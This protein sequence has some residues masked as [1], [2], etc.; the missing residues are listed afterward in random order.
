MN[1]QQIDPRSL[2]P[3]PWN[4]NAVGPENME[5]LIASLERH[6]WVRP[7]L[8]RE[9]GDRMQILGGQHR[10]EAAIILGHETVP[11]INLGEIDD[12]RA[13]EIGLI[14]N[15]RYGEDDAIGL[16]ELLHDLGGVGEMSNFLP[17]SNAELAALGTEIDDQE[18]DD[19]L[20][21]T[22]DEKDTEE[23]VKPVKTHQIMRF[24]VPIADADRI[25]DLVERVMEEQGFTEAD[26]L[27]NAGDALV[28]IA[29]NWS[30]ADV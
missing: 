19:L 23:R 11:V 16:M 27:A 5:K 30:D 2:Y 24:K 17:I 29:N 8:A 1:L 21:D 15:A 28:W 13:K 6:G 7:V 25:A 20:D 4:T 10:V 26:S 22:K 9:T 18:I 3:N 14:D 12:Q